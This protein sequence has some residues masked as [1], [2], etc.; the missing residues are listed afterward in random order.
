[1]KLKVVLIIHLF[2][3]CISI[4][5]Q[6]KASHQGLYATIGYEFGL[7]DAVIHKTAILFLI[8]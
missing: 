1:M 4:N 3:A 6:E 2:L 7:I 8:R 5:A